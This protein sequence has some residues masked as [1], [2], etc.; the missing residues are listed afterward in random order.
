MTIQD[1]LSNS[2]YSP[3]III[4]II[5]LDSKYCAITQE[6]KSV[7]HIKFIYIGKETEFIT[8]V[9]RHTKVKVSSKLIVLLRND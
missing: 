7:K 5:M 3:E 6:N 1:I 9:F 8:K 4:F 2:F